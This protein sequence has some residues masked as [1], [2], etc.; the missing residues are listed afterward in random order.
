VDDDFVCRQ[1]LQALLSQY[2]NCNIAVNGFE[3]LEAFEMAL[4]E[5]APYD[6]ICL[7]ILM[8]EMDGQ[9]VL[10]EIRRIESEP[11]TSHSKSVKIILISILSKIDLIK[12]ELRDK[13]EAFIAKP[14]E[15]KK[16]LDT[17]HNLGLISG[18]I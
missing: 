8:P 2:G 5:K 13:C 9:D 18:Q 3:A 11:E 10:K 14:V 7:D 15:K 12:G 1:V 6:L 16:L 17:L 4:D